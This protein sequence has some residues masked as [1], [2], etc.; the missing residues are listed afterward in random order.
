MEKA[1]QKWLASNW[2]NNLA[3]RI[4]QK[5]KQAIICY[6]WM[7]RMQYDNTSTNYLSIQNFMENR[8]KIRNS[9]AEFLIF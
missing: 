6:L 7:M 8:R 4:S 1:L 3:E 9:T 5:R 2:K